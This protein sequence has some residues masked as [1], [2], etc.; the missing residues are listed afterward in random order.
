[1][2]TSVTKYCQLL[3]TAAIGVSSGDGPFDLTFTTDRVQDGMIDFQPDEEFFDT[4]D[5]DGPF[6]KI[7]FPSVGGLDTITAHSATKEWKIDFEIYASLKQPRGNN[8][9][10]SPDNFENQAWVN[11][12]HDIDTEHKLTDPT[13]GD[14]S[15]IGQT[16]QVPNSSATYRFS[17]WFRK[18]A[19][20]TQFP[21]LELSFMGDGTCN[22]DVSTIIAINTND[23]TYHILSGSGTATVTDEITSFWRL[24]V[25]LAN[26][27]TG[28]ETLLAAIYP[29][30][31]T[32]SYTLDP[33]L[34]GAYEV[35]YPVLVNLDTYRNT[36]N[37]S[38]ILQLLSNL[39]NAWGD[40]DNFIDG[41]EQFMGIEGLSTEK[42]SA[43]ID[44]KPDVGFVSGTVTIKLI[45]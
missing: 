45:C 30:A 40:R 26:N 10:Y 42:L 16:I 32:T 35:Y 36:L 23:G 18:T 3:K 20:A 25:E 4:L 38:F 24:D 31:C 15:Y 28:N 22:D 11:Y 44:A 43:P 17:A 33:T 1:M 34:V 6:L 29:A 19:G 39:I 27:S 5:Q 37:Y 14:S 41:C 7:M 9:L 12:S 13:A 8:L 21:A 2:F